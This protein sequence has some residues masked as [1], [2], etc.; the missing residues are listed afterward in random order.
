MG[1]A[2]QIHGIIS[3]YGSTASDAIAVSASGSN[4]VI[5]ENGAQNTFPLTSVSEID[6]NGQ[7]GGDNVTI[8][9]GNLPAEINV[10]DSGSGNSLTVFGVPDAALNRI[11][12]TPG[13]IT[14]TDGSATETVGYSGIDSLIVNANGNY[15]NEVID[16]GRNTIINGGR[17]RNTITITATTGSGVVINGG[18]GA[19]SYIVDLGS[20]AGPVTVQ[21]SN[22]TATNSLLVN[23]A[24]GDNSI[25]AAG[26]QITSGTQ[27]ITDTASLAN[28]TVTG[29]S[30][31]NQLTVSSLT[32]P[33]QNVTLIG[34]GGTNTYTVNAGTVNVVAGTGVNVLNVTGGT[35]ASITAPAGDTKPLVFAHGYSVLDNGTLSVPAK[36]VLANAVSANGQ[37]LTA[38]LAA[39]PAHGTVSIRAD[40]SFTYTPA[41]SFV[42]TDSFTYQAKGSDGTLSTAAPVTI[43]VTYRFSGF[44]APLHPNMAYALGRTIP[45]KFQLADANGHLITS[46]GAVTS[47][48]VAPVN[49]SGS[50][51]TPFNPTAA[52]NTGLRNDGSQYIF[53][54][55][56]KG[57]AAGNYM[58]LL[59]L[60]DGTTQVLSLSLSPSG[61]FQLTDGAASGYA[62]STANQVLYGTLTVAVQDDTGAGIDPNE[63]A[64]INDAMSYLNTTLGSFG[65]DLSWAAPCTAADVTI[66]FA[67]STPEGSASDGVLGFTTADND[68][69]LVTGWNF[70]TGADPT[71]GGAGQFDFQ[72][73]ATHELAHTVGLGESSD[74]N[75]VMYEY[76]APGT[77]RRTFTDS[78]LSLIN[79]DA[80]RFMKVE[81]AALQPLP[82]WAPA[83]EGDGGAGLALLPNG[84]PQTS[85]LLG[86]TVANPLAVPLTPDRVFFPST[87]QPLPDRSGS[88]LTG[89]SGNPVLIGG[90]TDDLLIGGAGRD[91][92]VGGMACHPTRGAD[93]DPVVGADTTE[94]DHHGEALHLLLAEW[95]A[96]KNVPGDRSVWSDD[97][98]FR[99]D[100]L[101]DGNATLDVLAGTWGQDWFSPGGGSSLLT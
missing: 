72:T 61:A 34:G 100:Q 83:A 84:Q 21:N 11:T 56:T 5:S 78:N 82:S 9:F 35:V 70:Y 10:A 46:L 62:S 99:T 60:S 22:S 6:I 75:S 18:P 27:T 51:G 29:G 42:G 45:I 50:P 43:Q 79:T 12:K 2:K 80:D 23:G 63:L 16:P 41:A 77:V 69:Y 57:L 91:L 28:L 98:P 55:Q 39:G 64:R 13:T 101:A 37:A 4:L 7:G 1:R 88:I 67:T 87:E 49:A 53:N 59:S 76:L 96:A 8:D 65:V 48:Q 95:T 47:L 25:T 19:N 36:G 14:W 93:G 68:V 94:A 66:H 97:S 30:G 32:V 38:V 86:P 17:G 71:Q 85:S 26:N 58:I 15:A 52:G 20:L 89:C 81:P 3:V 40:G 33:V 74:P 44:L 24:A 90:A 73:L 31:N 54:W 92:L